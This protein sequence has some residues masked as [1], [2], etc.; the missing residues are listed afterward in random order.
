[1]AKI[2]TEMVQNINI[3]S[4][5]NRTVN[6]LNSTS[7]NDIK[8]STCVLSDETWLY[9]PS[10]NTSTADCA[11]SVHFW[12]RGIFDSPDS[13]F[14]HSRR[15]LLSRLEAIILNGSHTN[16]CM[17]AFSG[18]V[19][20][21]NQFVLPNLSVDNGQNGMNFISSNDL[22]SKSGSAKNLNASQTGFMTSMMGTLKQPKPSLPPQQGQT[23][24][25]KVENLSN[26]LLSNSLGAKPVVKSGSCD[27]FKTTQSISTNV[28][29]IARIQEDKLKAQV[30]A[31]AAA[32]AGRHGS[33][34]SLNRTSPTS[35]Y[36][37]IA[38]AP[39]SPRSSVTKLLNEDRDGGSVII[40]NY[41][42]VN[43]S[44][45]EYD[46]SGSFLRSRQNSYTLLP[47]K[48]VLPCFYPDASANSANVVLN[49]KFGSDGLSCSQFGFRPLRKN[50][51]PPS[52]KPM[53]NYKS[54][55]SVQFLTQMDGQ[56]E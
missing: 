15:N 4:S 19:P 38:S 10:T 47:Q 24:R 29:E 35:S 45:T 44:L 53:T 32:A 22:F 40:T 20:S 27:E 50:S 17:N 46:N 51:D 33:Q 41:P 54:V 39:E 31:L 6:V 7:R 3:L 13:C 26:N 28:Q 5:E 36:T 55:A 25:S 11:E 43:T 9:K 16:L 52:S 23:N 2:E 37:N 21:L 56:N 1:M 30:A 14:F 48:P 8:K 42:N 12:L 34:N 18:S 49:N